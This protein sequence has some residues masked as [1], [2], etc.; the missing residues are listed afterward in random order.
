L[1][2]FS[3]L[4]KHLRV[5]RKKK[6]ELKKNQFFN[7]LGEYF[8]WVSTFDEIARTNKS[9]NASNRIRSESELIADFWSLAEFRCGVPLFPCWALFLWIALD[10]TL[11]SFALPELV[12]R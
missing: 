9:L 6:R 5:S 12:S 7:I 11:G 4:R 8:E 3:F 10:P 1:S 2:F